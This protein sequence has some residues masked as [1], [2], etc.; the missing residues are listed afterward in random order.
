VDPSARVAARRA[1]GFRDDEVV[2]TYCGGLDYYQRTDQML[3]LW[4][5]AGRDPHIRFLLVTNDAPHAGPGLSA[6]ERFGPRLVR[7]SVPRQDVPPTLAAGDIGFMLRDSRVMNAA[8][9][10]V[11]FAEYLAAGLA[12]VTSPGVGDVSEFVVERDLGVLVNGGVV[13]DAGVAAVGA[14]VR[15]VCADRA[16][17]RARAVA[18]AEERYDWFAHRDTFRELYGPPLGTPP[19][20]AS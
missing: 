5:R 14:L 2:F 12:I 18:L 8:A 19:C 3:D 7:R 9:S 16:D 17:F 11:K 6:I 15:R 13:D 20:A 1:M 4:E 10:P